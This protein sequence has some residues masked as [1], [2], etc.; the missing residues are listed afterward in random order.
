MYNVLL[1]P[2]VN[3]FAVDRCIIS[4][5][6]STIISFALLQIGEQLM[7]NLRLGRNNL[8]CLCNVYYVFLLLA[9]TETPSSPIILIILLKI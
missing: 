4:Y 3:P 9:C 2:G 1:P 7:N 6:V 5:I 8:Y